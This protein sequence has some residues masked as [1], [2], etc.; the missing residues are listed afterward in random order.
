MGI[1]ATVSVVLVGIV[2]ALS[3]CL[4]VTPIVV[5]RES[6]ALGASECVSCLE[7]PG[8]C[9]G[10]IADC[11]VDPRFPRCGGIYDCMVERGCLAS[12]GV[13]DKIRC[14]LPCAQEAGVADVDDPLVTDYL[15]ALLL[16]AQKECP[17]ACALT[18]GGVGF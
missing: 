8:G 18:E 13:D 3:G 4:D 2:R 17:A 12:P 7:S 16:C 1:I 5:E 15:L 10:L 14:S 9:A 6:S 11:R